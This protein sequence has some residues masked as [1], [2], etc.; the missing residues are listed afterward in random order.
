M[1]VT[2]ATKA[3]RGARVMARAFESSKQ[4]QNINLNLSLP[5]RHHIH[6]FLNAY[7]LHLRFSYDQL[8]LSSDTL[9]AALSEAGRFSLHYVSSLPPYAQLTLDPLSATS[10][11]RL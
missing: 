5:P 1:V 2:T 8:H 6:T 10:L 3:G 4:Q 11:L 7:L 9:H